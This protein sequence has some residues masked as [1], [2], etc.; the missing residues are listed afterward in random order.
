MDNKPRAVIIGAGVGGLA[1][2]NFLAKNG[3]SVEIYEKNANPGGRCGQMIQ[4]GHRFDLGATILLM[5]SLYRKVLS[6][7]GI[8]LDKDLETTSLEPVYKLFFSDGSDFAFTRNPEQMKTQLEAI[9]TGSFPKY[10]EY[11]KEGYE[12]FNLS[13]NDLLGKN[14][15]HLFQFVNFKSMRLLLK[16]KTYL[17]HTDYIQ[18]YFNDPHLRMAFTFQNIY[19]GQNPYDAPAFFSML[20]GAEI[21]EGALFPK[22]GMHRLV[23]KLLE[24]ANQN[25]VQIHYKK[26]AEKIV[27]NGRKAEGIL[28]DDGTIVHADLVVAN[29]DLPYVYDKLL[30]DKQKT[31]SLKKKKY[32]CSAIVFHWGVDKVYPQLDH[33]SVFLNDPYKQG[34]NKIFK[35]KSLSENPSFYIHAPV[36]T[37][38]S[39][40]PENHDT[41]SV[42]VPV[43]HLDSQNHQDWGKLKQRAREGVISRLEEAGLHDIEEHIK[44]EICYLPKTWESTCN[45]TRGSV[46]GSLSHSIFQMGYFRPHNQHK[47]Y[48]NLYFAGGSTHPGNGVP[49]VLLGAKLTSERILK[50]AKNQN[51]N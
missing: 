2:A 32:S 10:Q 36:R 25:S 21:A 31:R 8:D 45:V 43:A 14:F 16:L 7:L 27:L 24:L 23:E 51:F 41:L 34:L 19:V 26:P 13:M 50:D 40:A 39:A 20:P 42:I 35:E 44:F 49:L 30:H 47:K 5:P 15:D 4:D 22:G 29:A 38:K 37:D 12:Y 46:F 3:Y 18:R 33:H 28:L 9:E 1:T 48:R 11:V 6:E 17:K